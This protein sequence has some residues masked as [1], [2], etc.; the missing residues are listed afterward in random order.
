[1]NISGVNQ[2]R[3]RAFSPKPSYYLYSP[4]EELFRL[5]GHGFKESI[6]LDSDK[7]VVLKNEGTNEI[8]II[9]ASSGFS[10]GINLRLVEF[11]IVRGRV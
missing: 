7:T 6:K 8:V 1:M 4:S 5:R 2:N 9:I 10:A 3:I 11:D